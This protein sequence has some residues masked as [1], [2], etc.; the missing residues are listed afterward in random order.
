MPLTRHLMSACALVLGLLG[1]AG[2]FA[3]DQVLRALGAAVSPGSLVPVQ[4]AGA[5]YL[6]FGSLNWMARGNLIGGIYSRPVAVGNLMHFLVA[7][8]ALIKAAASNPG[9]SLVWPVALVYA[10]FA[11]AFGL[12]IFRH[13]IRVTSAATD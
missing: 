5:L 13:P 6:G 10:G 2:T 7:G 12:I 8:L 9:L 3:P 1:L 11:T 4:V